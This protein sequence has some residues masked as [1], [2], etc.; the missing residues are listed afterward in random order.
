MARKPTERAAK[1]GR[2]TGARGTGPGTPSISGQGWAARG[3]SSTLGLALASALSLFLA[4]PP[5]GAWPLAWVAPMPWLLLARRERLPGRRPYLCVWL[6][7]LVY[8][9]ATLHSLTLPHWATAVG[10]VVLSAYLGCYQALFVAVVRAGVHRLNLPLVAVAPVAWTG[11]ECAQTHLLDGFN[12]ASLGHTQYRWLHLIQIADLGGAY[13]VGTIVMFGAACAASSAP[14]SGKAFAWRPLAVGAAALAATLVYGA[15]R[16]GQAGG[17]S[18]IAAAIVQGSID[19]EFDDDRRPPE[20][21][22]REY[23]DLTRQAVEVRNDLD[24]ILWPE[25][26]WQNAWLDVRPD[27]RLA[28]TDDPNALP[29]LRTLAGSYRRLLEG[30]AEDLDA[31]LLVG[32]AAVEFGDGFV[33]SYNSA[34]LVDP[35]TGAGPRYDKRTLVMFGEYIPFGETFPW[36]YR[37]SPMQAG[38]EPGTAMPAMQARNVRLATCICFESSLPQRVRENVLDLRARGEEPDVLVNLTNDGWFYGTSVLDLHL[39]CGVFRA[40]ECRKPLLIAANTGFSAHID[41]NGGLRAVGPRRKAAVLYA[42][43]ELDARDSLYLRIGDLAAGLCLAGTAGIAGLGAWRGRR[44][45]E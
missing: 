30:F 43:V 10:W 9:L 16:L 36:L 41:A 33:H 34:L 14:W 2:E 29:R 6:A 21:I 8:W 25:G 28:D 4:Q 19:T 38:T 7:G 32:L 11:L 31:P 15:V 37:F 1:G 18:G 27:A 12:F 44:G 5:V 39:V 26:Q 17:P 40:V 3:A 35:R 42:D 22:M 20:D 23:V 24:L 45:A 13:A